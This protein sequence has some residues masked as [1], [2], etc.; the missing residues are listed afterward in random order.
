MCVYVYVYVC[1]YME[2]SINGDPKNGW[3]LTDDSTKMELGGLPFQETS[4]YILKI[5]LK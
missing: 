5:I 3:F 1:I 4:T 2:M